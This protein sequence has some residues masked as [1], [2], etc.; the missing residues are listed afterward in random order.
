M[1]N[2]ITFILLT[3]LASA[4]SAHRFH[5][6]IAELELNT[7]T[8][9]AELAIRVFNDDLE[10]ALSTGKE[11]DVR[12]E[13]T[14]DVDQQILRYVREHVTLADSSG[15]KVQ[16]LWVGRETEVQSSWIYVEAA[17]DGPASGW[18]IADSLFFELFNDQVNSV[19]VVRDGKKG[20]LAFTRGEGAKVVP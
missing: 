8:K 7:K 16:W 10:R 18:Q 11:K 2:L 20:G 15:Q 3:L 4:A 17:F 19:N 6:S 13:T 9:R 1:K 12:L 14:A 5:A